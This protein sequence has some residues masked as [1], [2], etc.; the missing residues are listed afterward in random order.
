MFLLLLLPE[1]SGSLCSSKGGAW[2]SDRRDNSFESSAMLNTACDGSSRCFGTNCMGVKLPKIG[3]WVILRGTHLQNHL[4]ECLIG[5][6]L[7]TLCAVGFDTP[8]LKLD[9][10]K[11]VLSFIWQKSIWTPLKALIIFASNDFFPPQKMFYISRW[12]CR[13]SHGSFFFFGKT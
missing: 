13:S 7:Q 10:K 2:Y 9:K 5:T 4:V 6:T 12:K 1:V 3:H 8:G 11:Q